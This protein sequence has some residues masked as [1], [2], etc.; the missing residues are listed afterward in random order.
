MN[1]TLQYSIFLT[2]LCLVAGLLLTF[3]NSFTSKI[4]TERKREEVR[5]ALQEYFNYDDYGENIAEDFTNLSD[6]ID[7]IYYGF[8]SEGKV[9]AVIYKTVASGYGGPVVSLIAIKADG[10]FEKLQVIDV[11][12]E[13]PN[14]GTRAK[15]H[16]FKIESK[17]VTN[18]SYELRA[19]VT[20]T[21]QAVGYGIDAA[22]AH[23]KTIQNTLGGIRK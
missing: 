13:T 7:E 20:V 23:F 9:E 18:Y 8:D 17:N 10:T 2:V 11:S 6:Y 12:K 1:K 22:A 19:G 5:Q 16:D 14:I 15:D 4:I 3:V 21:T